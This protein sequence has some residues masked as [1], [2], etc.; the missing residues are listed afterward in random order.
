MSKKNLNKAETKNEFYSLI[1]EFI[2]IF[3]FSFCILYVK[4]MA[5]TSSEP[6]WILL[7]LISVVLPLISM[8]YLF[9]KRKQIILKFTFFHFL[10]FAYLAWF[11]ISGFWTIDK[12]NFIEESSHNIPFILLLIFFSFYAHKLNLTKILKVFSLS[13]FIVSIIG[14]LQYFGWDGNLF[15]QTAAPGSTFVNK[16]YA[17]PLISTLLPFVVFFLLSTKSRS[18]S[19][20]LTIGLTFSLTY[21]LVAATRSSW[22]AVFL[23]FLLVSGLF[24][25]FKRNRKKISGKIFKRRFI[26]ILVAVI[27]I[28]VIIQVR[29]LKK[30][31]PNMPT[32]ISSQIEALFKISKDKSE[33]NE[34]IKKEFEDEIKAESDEKS[35]RIELREKKKKYNSIKSINQRLAKWKNCVEMFKDKPVSGFGLGSFNAAY[36]L[37]YKKAI[38]DLAYNGS[39]FYGGVHNDLYQTLVE[40]GIIGLLLFSGLLILF[41]IFAFRLLRKGDQE[42]LI[43]VI[44]S[45]TGFLGLILDSFFNFPLRLPTYLFLFALIYGIIYSLYLR[46]FPKSIFNFKINKIGMLVM[47]IIFLALTIFSVNISYRKVLSEINLKTAMN[48]QSEGKTTNLWRYMKKTIDYW[49]NRSDNLVFGV[50]LCFQNYSVNK[51]AHSYNEIV[52]YNNLA[53]RSMPYQF[54]PNLV[55]VGLLMENEN[56]KKVSNIDQNVGLMVKVSPPGQ[57]RIRA[58]TMAAS[59]YEKMKEY[60]KSLNYYRRLA[61]QIP[62]NNMLQK[63]IE[64]LNFMMENQSTEQEINK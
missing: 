26:N 19:I 27:L 57:Q 45:L 24:I 48:L 8:I 49:P 11:L 20:I 35:K 46:T 37:Y 17:T 32:T 25:I 41:F 3:V 47:I 43:V 36:P 51:T 23:S 62:N 16:N 54:M 64:Y 31:V 14:L 55:R 6:R 15:E 9:F 39:Y 13:L 21:F 44:A 18:W 60:K 28:F 10:T 56:W 22:V 53:L 7:N 58:L 5:F 4:K 61:K 59:L 1:N 63:R 30:N 34:D 42:N 33:L 38:K 29:D 40:L 50:G 12:A 52:K 2:Y